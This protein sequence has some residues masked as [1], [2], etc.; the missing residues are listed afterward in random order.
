MKHAKLLRFGALFVVSLTLTSFQNCA[1]KQFAEI[2]QSQKS[3]KLS[4]ETVFPP[5]DASI[6][7]AGTP[8][9]TGSIDGS[10]TGSTNTGGSST[11]GGSTGGTNS[12]SNGSTVGGTNTTTGTIAGSGNGGGSTIP[13][14]DGSSTST[15]PI[16]TGTTNATNSFGGTTILPGMS[17]TP[18]STT[19]T[20][21]TVTLPTGLLGG[22]VS[23]DTPISTM[24]VPF[25]G[26]AVKVVFVCSDYRSDA[27]GN[28]ATANILRVN[29]LD[30]QGNVACSFTNGNLRNYIVQNKA[31]DMGLLDAACPNL[32]AGKYVMQIQ[33]PNRTAGN[34]QYLTDGK[35][36]NLIMGDQSNKGFVLQRSATGWNRSDVRMSVLTDRNPEAKQADGKSNMT[37]L[38]S[39]S[40]CDSLQSPLVIHLNS[41]INRAEHM[42]L[43]SPAN[44]VFFDI[45]GQNALPVAHTP[46]RISWQRSINYVYIVLPDA[47]G[48][49]R[50]I[51]QMFGNNTLGPDGKFALNGYEALGKYDAKDATGTKPIGNPDGYINSKDPIYF[52]L[53]VWR[54]ENFDGVAQANELYTLTEAGITTIDLHYNPSFYE[55]DQYGNETR[56]KSVVQTRD[57]KL[58]LM[59]DLW[60]NQQ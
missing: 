46:K 27:N 16:I 7:G 48:Q 28:L 6:P 55:R 53:R 8:N 21:T 32:P 36:A 38:T 43:S 25:S 34:K 12:G 58:H 29:L 51:D 57:G 15:T 60:F 40:Q 30:T 14:S 1:N 24:P 47:N 49:V 41:D 9:T 54:D 44:G 45:L 22:G 19:S 18:N 42:V 23:G 17:G 35:T 33:D 39:A 3:D 5:G 2:A 20:A 50:G 11:V 37:M 10:S 52:A 59:F 31:F 13:G 56:Y 4:D 26:N